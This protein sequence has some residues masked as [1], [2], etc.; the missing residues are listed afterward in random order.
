M[1]AA[2]IHYTNQAEEAALPTFAWLLQD[3]WKVTF[4]KWGA[5]WSANPPH[6][7]SMSALSFPVPPSSANHPLWVTCVKELEKPKCPPGEAPLL[8]P[9]TWLPCC[10]FHTCHT[11]T[12]AAHLMVGH[13]FTGDYSCHF[14]PNFPEF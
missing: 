10:P 14:H 6:E 2:A 7:A 8:I 13:T 9:V 1:V 12:T 4:D 5:E 11:T 3:M